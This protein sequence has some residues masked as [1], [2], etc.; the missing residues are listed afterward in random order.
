MANIRH[1]EVKDH[2]KEFLQELEAKL[3]IALDAV[4]M[5]AESHAKVY[6]PVDTGRLRASITHEATNDT[7]IIGTNVEYGKYQELG[8]SRMAGQPFLRPAI[9]NHLEEYKR[10]MESILNG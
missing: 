2:R 1:M 6:C 9:V 8:T 4:G 3:G 10:I 7:V 5:Q